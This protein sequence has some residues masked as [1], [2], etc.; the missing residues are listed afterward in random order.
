MI[1]DGLLRLASS[2]G[3]IVLCRDLNPRPSRQE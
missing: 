2:S 3:F 1:D